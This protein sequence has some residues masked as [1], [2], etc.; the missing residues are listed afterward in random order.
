MGVL[1]GMAGKSLVP[2]GAPSFG[3]GGINMPF[4]VTGPGGIPLPGFGGGTQTS[5]PRGFHLNKHAL[6]ASKKHGAV[7]A[8]TMCVRN[9]HMN[10]MNY[11][12]LT[13]SLRRVKRATKIVSKLH[14]FHAPAR[15]RLSAP[16]AV[17]E[18]L[19]ITSG[20]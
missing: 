12:A 16:V 3:G 7:A 11:R 20:R 10:P 2:S 19:R 9:R 1:G 17:S 15:R 6:A 8:R 18:N 14:H 5:C 13:R 4:K